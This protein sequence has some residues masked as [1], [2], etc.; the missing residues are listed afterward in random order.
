M[1]IK[2]LHPQTH[3]FVLKRRLF[4]SLFLITRDLAI[5]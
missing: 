4:M 1:S 3:A 5:A 2:A